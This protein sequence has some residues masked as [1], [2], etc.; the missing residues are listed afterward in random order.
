MHKHPSPTR[1]DQVL[2]LTMLFGMLY[3]IQGISEPTQGLLSQPTR[4]LLTDWGY[5]TE[6]IGPFMGL[7]ALPWSIKPLFGFLTDF[8][9]LA[10]SR[11]R[12]YLLLTTAATALTLILL[13]FL[14]PG[15]GRVALLFTWLVIPTIGVAFSDVV[16]DALMVETGQPRGLTGR[17][18]SV[19]WACIWAATILTGKLGGWLSEHQ[20]QDLGYLIA[21]LATALSLIVAFAV[22]REPPRSGGPHSAGEAARTLWRSLRHPGILTIGAFLFLWT[23]NPFSATVLQYHMTNHLKFSE[24]FYGDT[25]SVQAVAS[26][27]ASV[28]Y[29]FYC[30]RLTVGQLVHLSIVTGVMATV[31][32]WWL[33]GEW[34]AWIISFVVGFVYMTATMVQLDLA[35]R[36]CDVQTAGTTVALLMALSNLSY[37]TSE[38]LGGILYERLSEWRDPTTAFQIVVAIGA[39]FTSGCWLLVPALRRYCV[40]REEESGDRSQESG[41]SAAS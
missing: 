35:A 25:I 28:C 39:L 38:A 20:R 29:A 10:G 2:G 27:L 18:Q 40:P 11:R 16:V 31:L 22:V 30:R 17:L 21:G 9:P 12:S 4:S 13:Y 5:T 41:E 19:Q 24:Q 15:N 23:F 1:D 14:P 32:Y 26:V 37:S 33:E 8:V 3:F 34:S 6:V 7:L 36:V